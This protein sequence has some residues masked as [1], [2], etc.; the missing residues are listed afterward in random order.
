MMTGHFARVLLL[1]ATIATIVPAAACSRQ[2]STPR[3]TLSDADQLHDAA[4]QLSNV[5][6]YDIFSPPQASRVYAYASIAAY[7]ALR[8][9]DTT[10]RSLAGQVHHLPP[11]P[12]PPAGAQLSLPLAGVHAFMTVGQALTFSRERM[13]SLRAA[14][15]ARYEARLPEDVYLR[16]IAYGDTVAQHILA[17]A[18]TDGYKQSRGY[19]KFSVSQRPGRWI[20]T[21]PAYMDAIEPSWAMIRPFV[22]DSA[23]QFRPA[24][25]LPF[26]STPASPFMRE[27]REVYE[28]KATLTDEQ[29]EILAFWDC[30]P[31]VMHVQGHTMYATKKITPGG[32]WMGIVATAA[33][34]AEADPVRAADAYARTAIAL[35]DG[36]ISSWDEKYRSAL[37][38]PETVIN[39]YIDEKWEPMLQTPPFPEYTSGHSVISTAAAV[40]LT[41]VFGDGFAFTDSTELEYGL[42]IRSFPSFNNAAA[43]AAIS[44][45]YGGIHYRRAIEEGVRQG[46]R[47]GALV[48]ERLRTRGTSPVLA[49]AAR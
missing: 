46:R 34:K 3:P 27:A 21:P 4:Y 17:W 14:M 19:P 45:L 26:D 49:T 47:V 8:H 12:A 2:T 16:S 41:D 38:R 33:R 31:Y 25:P 7:E 5:I 40:V 9:G 43:E 20:P 1:G 44:R 36:F 10:Y 28:I 24:P 39:K 30:N 13:D 29:K 48:V 18:G 32:H 15:D 22:M 42:P 6:V 35:A 11:V 37:V 23:S